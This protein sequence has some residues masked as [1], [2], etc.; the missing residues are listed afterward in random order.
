MWQ[1]I[2]RWRDRSRVGLPLVYP[3]CSHSLSSFTSFLSF[4]CSNLSF[5]PPLLFNNR[6]TKQENLGQEERT[7]PETKEENLIIL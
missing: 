7:N 1:A 3:I 6:R 5:L 2:E 4:L